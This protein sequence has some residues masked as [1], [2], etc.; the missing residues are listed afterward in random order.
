MSYRIK[1][2]E[3]VQDALRRIAHEQIDKARVELTDEGIDRHEGVHSARKRFKK[4]RGLLR[5]VRPQLQAYP[6]ENRW[7]RDVGRQ[8]SHV[9]DAQ[10]MVECFDALIEHNADAIDPRKLADARRWLVDRRQ[11]VAH[12]QADL[13]QRAAD[14]VAGLREARHRVERWELGDT[15][16]D[17]VRGGVKKVYKRGRKA[18]AHACDQPNDEAFHDWRKRVKYHWCHTRLLRN[19]WKEPMNARRRELKA[20]SDQLGDDHDLA[21]FIALLRDAGNSFS[22]GATRRVLLALADR[23]RGELLGA[24]IK[25]GRRVYAERGSAHARRIEAYWD[26]WRRRSQPVQPASPGA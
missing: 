12:Q 17:A 24:A 20:L 2:K 1:R 15:G 14:V 4:V 25:L 21:L 22:D 23:R 7:F 18:L 3:S 16:F 11:R 9:R 26:A 10:A 5:L 19:V 8:L 13:Q 6:Q